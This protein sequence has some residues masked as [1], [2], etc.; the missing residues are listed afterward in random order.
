MELIKK[1]LKNG[2]KN[3]VKSRYGLKKYAP[4]ILLR[5]DLL[6]VAVLLIM[7]LI[8]G[9]MT[10]FSACDRREE[11]GTDPNPPTPPY[12][13]VLDTLDFKVPANVV[14]LSREIANANKAM[15]DRL[16]YI[17]SFTIEGNLGIKE[18][19]FDLM[20]QLG[21]LERTLKDQ[22]RI[23]VWTGFTYPLEEEIVLTLAE[24][25]GSEWVNTT[26]RANPETGFMFWVLTEEYEEF[27]AL[28]H[29][30]QED[31][32]WMVGDFNVIST[33]ELVEQ[34]PQIIAAA[35]KQNVKIVH[36]GGNIVL[37]DRHGAEISRLAPFADKIELS[38]RFVAGEWVYVSVAFVK[39]FRDRWQNPENFENNSIFAVRGADG[40]NEL[41]GYG[42]PLLGTDTINAGSMGEWA[43][44]KTQFYFP[45]KLVVN[46]SDHPVN[47]TVALENLFQLIGSDL[48]GSIVID[49]QASA[50]G[51]LPAFV[52]GTGKN[53]ENGDKVFDMIRTNVTKDKRQTLFD[54]RDK[55]GEM[56]DPILSTF[57]G[58]VRGEQTIDRK[59]IID[60]NI[61]KLQYGLYD[62]ENGNLY[63]LYES[64]EIANS[65][66]GIVRP[67]NMYPEAPTFD[68]CFSKDSKYI[69]YIPD[70]GTG[71]S[72]T[73]IKIDNRDPGGMIP[74]I[75]ALGSAYINGQNFTI[76]LKNSGVNLLLCYA[77]QN[78]ARFPMNSISFP[79]ANITVESL[80][81]EWAHGISSPGASMSTMEYTG[82]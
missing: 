23:F 59:P 27:K 71:E 76:H 75:L 42:M 45:Q 14:D 82:K 41:I 68:L 29:D 80:V 77:Q 52:P 63:M 58:G 70:D 78:S 40:A 31:K 62:D 56:I 11:P 74:R 25:Q 65:G 67:H 73:A 30:V 22:K 2:M 15:S 55:D 4:L 6:R 37:L 38:G 60:M 28:G 39:A 54:T 35:E 48:H 72:W 51:G 49:E 24:L 61:K 66:D 69:F 33:D 57:G 44:Y 34:I 21:T 17:R 43:G 20:R 18:E 46:G 19:N 16:K 12:E 50:P 9:G 81:G 64:Y 1:I 8:I 7:M 79:P 36:N 47:A 26:L 53:G 13:T 3:R 32:R 5:F 10:L